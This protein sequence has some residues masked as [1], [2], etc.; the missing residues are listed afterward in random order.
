MARLTLIPIL[1]AI[2]VTA[3]QAQAAPKDNGTYRS[4]SVSTP[5][6]CNQMCQN[7]RVNCV[8]TL[9]ESWSHRPG[10]LVCHLNNGLG[11]D[12]PFEPRIPEPFDLLQAEADLNAYRAL[13]NL[14]PV[15]L[16]NNLN[17]ASQLHSDDQAAMDE[18]SHYS[19]D[20]TVLGDRALAS[21][22]QYSLVAEN[23]ASGQLSWERVFVAWQESPGHNVN[24]LNPD[25]TEVGIALTYDANTGYKTF[26][27]MMLG[28]PAPSGV[29]YENS[30][31]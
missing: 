6:D 10:Y 8:G 28:A 31:N 2:S 25:V 23:V 14:E 17:R 18:A 4:V 1:L 5:E 22:Y 29:I 26:W 21:G 27:T 9:M 24:L 12:S 19:S 16:N 7:D 13:H 11:A 3:C 15:S 30:Q 20:G